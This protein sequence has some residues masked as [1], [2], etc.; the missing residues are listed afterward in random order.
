MIHAAAPAK[1]AIGIIGG[2]GKEGQGIALRLAA[3]GYRVKVGSRYLTKARGVAALLGDRG[4]VPVE[5]DSNAAVVGASE[6]NVLTVPFRHAASTID[7]LLDA[8]VPGSLLIDVT[9]PVSFAA[10]SVQYL[11]VP[12]GSAAQLIREHL[13]DEVGLAAALKT[14]PAH[15]LGRLEVALD[16]DTFIC[17]DSDDSRRRAMEIFRNLP[18]LQ[19]VDVG[20]LHVAGTLERMTVLLININRRYKIHEGRFRVTGLE[21]E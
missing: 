15:R 17:G 2:T 4:G 18:G 19:P 21:H 7:G 16:C 1:P 5:A 20:D 6:V 13:P 12:Q 14:L 3:A 8:F 9:V 10:G 11:D